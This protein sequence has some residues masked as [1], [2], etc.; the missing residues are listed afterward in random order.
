[1]EDQPRE[2]EERQ[3]EHHRHAAMLHQ[4]EEEP[5]GDEREYE[6]DREEDAEGEEIEGEYDHEVQDSQPMILGK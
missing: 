6:E 3:R 4:P 5:I 2:L 1:M